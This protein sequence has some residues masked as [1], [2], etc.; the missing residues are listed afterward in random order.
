VSFSY[1]K[2]SK[3]KRR[4][5]TYGGTTFKAKLKNNPFRSASATVELYGWPKEIH[6]E[7]LVRKQQELVIRMAKQESLQQQVISGHSDLEKL[8]STNKAYGEAV[9]QC[10]RDLQKVQSLVALR[11]ID[12]QRLSLYIEADSIHGLAILLNLKSMVPIYSP[13]VQGED[14]AL[15]WPLLHGQRDVFI[16]MQEYVKDVSSTVNEIARKKATTEDGFQQAATT[17]LTGRLLTDPNQA[18]FSSAQWDI[19]VT[20]LDMND[21]EQKT[22][23]Q[24]SRDAVA[25]LQ[26]DLGAFQRKKEVLFAKSREERL[27]EFGEGNCQAETREATHELTLDWNT[28]Q[29]VITTL[30]A[31]KYH[32]G[33]LAT[34]KGTSTTPEAV[35]CIWRVERLRISETD[36][37]PV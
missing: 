18:D 21:D 30:S 6:H 25:K 15:A 12:P 34:L 29:A 22:L 17:L 36:I 10:L 5:W 28:N 16:R 13:L 11:N 32:V 24:K 2:S 3:E 14:T 1:G 31:N 4:I 20:P 27:R 23:D 9:N 7:E 33:I 37:G 26:A 19:A 8:Q 35:G